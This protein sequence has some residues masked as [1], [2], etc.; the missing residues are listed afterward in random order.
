MQ[1]Q[2]MWHSVFL[3]PHQHLVLSVFFI[4][5]FLIGTVLSHC[6]LNLHFPNSWWCWES[7][8]VLICHPYSLFSET[9]LYFYCPFSDWTVIFNFQFCLF[10][11][12]SRYESFVRYVVCKYFLPVYSLSLHPLNKDF[13]QSKIL[14]FWWSSF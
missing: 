11:I 14:K 4:L 3:H 2:C 7:F 8:L 13:L 12:Y 1:E 6:S 10:F 5:A 9:S